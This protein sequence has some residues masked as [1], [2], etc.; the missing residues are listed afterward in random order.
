MVVLSSHA[1]TVKQVRSHSIGNG[2]GWPP[3]VHVWPKAKGY[4]RG[5]STPPVCPVFASIRA[6]AERF[7]A[8]KSFEPLKEELA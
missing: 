3:R 1:R 6:A 2:V 8:G 7:W 5:S 4:G